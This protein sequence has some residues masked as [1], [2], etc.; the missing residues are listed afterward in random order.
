MESF[1]LTTG[2]D[3]NSP[4]AH[5]AREEYS[6][7][8]PLSSIGSLIS[9]EDYEEMLAL[10]RAGPPP[11]SPPVR[12]QAEEYRLLRR[13]LAEESTGLRTVESA[14]PPAGDGEGVAVPTLPGT[15][16]E[17]EPDEI[18]TSSSSS[19][20]PVGEPTE[21]AGPGQRRLEGL[22]PRRKEPYAVEFH[23][24]LDRI[25]ARF[26]DGPWCDRYA[27]SFKRMGPKAA[28]EAM[29][30]IWEVAV[31]T[32]NRGGFAAS[33]PALAHLEG[34]R[35]WRRR[36]A[37]L[38]GVVHANPGALANALDRAPSL[39]ASD[40]DLLGK[41]M[42]EALGV[43]DCFGEEIGFWGAV[44]TAELK[45]GFTWVR[46]E[47]PRCAW[48]LESVVRG[49]HFQAAPP[50]TSKKDLASMFFGLRFR[51]CLRHHRTSAFCGAR[52]DGQCSA[53]IYTG[54]VKPIPLEEVYRRRAKGGKEEAPDQAP[55]SSHELRRSAEPKPGNYSA[56]CWV[57]FS[58]KLIGL[59]APT[60]RSISKRRA[61]AI[62]AGRFWSREAGPRD[63]VLL[64]GLPHETPAA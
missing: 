11:Y 60:R 37:L 21:T 41:L 9:R 3:T 44:P 17:G 2:A 27:G 36:N 48:P 23:D 45:D 59:R 33:F 56:S 64:Y 46:A 25:K 28:A 38:N 34:G 47:G 29:R 12:G 6:S 30:N 26:G 18:R 1:D 51:W 49:R 62:A 15:E 43:G 4:F 14:L 32:D 20:V 42:D 58:R 61:K 31:R 13:E 39:A 50:G 10:A 7:G 40:L 24:Y 53:C 54:V 8:Y 55:S 52:E 16:P 35:A 5:G 22:F 57:R 63:A 19:S